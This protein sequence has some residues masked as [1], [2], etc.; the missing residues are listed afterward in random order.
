MG[1]LHG[2]VRTSGAGVRRVQPAQPGKRAQTIAARVVK[3]MVH[4]RLARQFDGDHAQAR[5]A[6]QVE[7]QAIVGVKCVLG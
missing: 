1:G 3:D 6:A 2:H 7:T 5:P 4:S